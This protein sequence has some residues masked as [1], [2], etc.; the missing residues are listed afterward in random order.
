YLNGVWPRHL[1]L[2][3]AGVALSTSFGARTAFTG[4]CLAPAAAA[5]DLFDRLLDGYAVADVRDPYSRELFSDD[6][7][8][9]S[10]DDTLLGLDAE[11]YDGRAS[12]SVMVCGQSD[13]VDAGVEAV[14]RTVQATLEKWGV[15]GSQVG[16]VETMPGEDRRVYELIEPALPDIQFYPF[17]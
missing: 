8:T 11:T 2:L 4:A 17:V 9:V 7:V 3:G 14:A 12:R 15:E 13:H 10:G 6:R 5:R 16:Y 1:L